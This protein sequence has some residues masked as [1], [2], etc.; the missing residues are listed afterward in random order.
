VGS[1]REKSRRAK[2]VKNLARM[3]KEYAECVK[4]QIRASKKIKGKIKAM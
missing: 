3:L 2:Q 1:G 4:I